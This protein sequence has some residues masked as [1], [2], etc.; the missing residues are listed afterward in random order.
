[1]STSTSQRLAALSDEQKQLLAQRLSRQRSRRST[2]IPRRAQNGEP[3]PLSF[4]QQRFWLLHQL[5]A[6]NT[7][8]NCYELHRLSGPLDLDVLAR[9]LNEIARRHDG[10]RAT[11]VVDDGV[12][13]QR[14]HAPLGVP[15][16]VDDLRA[17]PDAERETQRKLQLGAEAQRPWDMANGPL[18]RAR[19]WR[20]GDEDHQLLVIMHHIVSDGWS[21]GVLIDE[22][23]RLYHAFSQGKPSPLP[24]LPIQYSD[25]AVWQRDWARSDDFERQIAYWKN[26]M[27]QPPVLQLP[28][29]RTGQPA[30]TKGTHK[31]FFLAPELMRDLR[32][33]CQA[34]GITV[35]MALLASFAV[36]L[37]RYSGQDDV[38]IGTPVA[39]RDRPELEHL[40]GCFMNPLPIRNDL[41]GNP[42]FRT[43]LRRVR[44]NALATF[45]NQNVPFDVLVRA[46]GASRD[47]SNTPLFQVMFL[48]QNFGVR[49][50]QMSAQG[51]GTRTVASMDE[52]K[53]P[54]DYEVPGDLTYP[55]ALEAL[56]VGPML[57]A[58][59][60]YAPEYAPIFSR[61]P[62]HMRTLLGAL[63]RNPEIRIGEA[64]WLTAAETERLLVEW[65]HEPLPA[66]SACVHELFEREAARQ[67][68]A[69][70]VIFNEARISYGELNARAEALASR[71]AAAGASVD[72][73]VGILLDRSIE[74][75]VAV[76][77]VMKSGGCY[78]PLD[79][80]YPPDRLRFIMQDA[81]IRVLISTHATLERIPELLADA[82][83]T[84]CHLEFI[85]DEGST[86]APAARRGPRRADAARLA[87]IIY[88]SGST[89]RPKGT[90]VTHASLAGAYH[91]WEREYELRS[92]KAHLQMASLSFDVFS[93]DLVRALCSGAAL[94]V[95]P[96]ELLFEPARLHALIEREQVDAA[97][98]VPVVLR[99]LVRHL[100]TTG[101][102][103]S[104]LRLLAAGSDSWYNQEYARLVELCGPETRVVNSY[105]LTEATIDS[106]YFDGGGDELAADGLVPLGRAFP[107]TEVLLLDGRMQLVPIGVPAEVMIGGAGLARGYLNRPD[108][109][110][111]RFV[112]H[113]FSPIP[114]ARLYRSGDLG[115]YLPDGTLELLGRTDQQVKLRGFRI[116]LAE[117]ES[118]LAAHPTIDAAVALVREDVPGD[119]R[120]VAYLVAAPGMTVNA[121]ELRRFARE[122]VPDYMVPSSI[123][124]LPALP[125]TPNG[126][127]DR[128]ALPAPDGE[129]QSEEAFV[130]PRT[131][132]ERQLATI[133]SGVLRVDQVGLNDN[134]FDLGGHS[135]LI[136]QLHARVVN[137][138]QRPDLTVVDLF[139]FPT[140]A[141]LAQHLTAKRDPAGAEFA[142]A[143]RRAERHRGAVR[144]PR[145]GADLRPTKDAG[146]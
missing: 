43:L 103:L 34:E 24:E 39:N 89:G 145:Q 104:R 122:T 80:A 106:T 19:V 128:L 5:G 11:F 108:L 51:L 45:A 10:L 65:N 95:A 84:N 30:S 36:L 6:T 135:L 109:T 58:S 26:A 49:S 68:D 75:V 121:A 116:E 70:A 140:V 44:T 25:F 123:V 67:P 144:R 107:G 72:V 136:V 86:A 93:G 57:A 110:A 66:P 88:T 117:V 31:R 3:L 54:D 60:E 35:F 61:F 74:M 146:E 96:Q 77:A 9:S 62:G 126:K 2:T 100:E 81:A 32:T 63:V 78:V 92:L 82:A 127:V 69:A 27:R 143:R 16:Q 120:L 52:M 55:V 133:W 139:R 112:P 130:A 38:V 33:L 87:Y 41:G 28:A 17:L 23:A 83:A 8:Y 29:I 40:I 73:P 48:L 85:D 111:E 46:V 13:Q 124:V 14:I 137:G 37:S 20:L 47:S 4:A 132:I 42:T 1:M 118:V 90:M 141:A 12:P 76:L 94:V 129:R 131:E 15:L 115:R 22:L 59:I 101:Q 114:G 56:E 79:A 134:F 138:L 98:F 97:E 7:A 102:T 21:L 105:G 18:L 99:D 53:V 119:R 50:L 142:S 125:L 71:L 113:P 91:A 64:P